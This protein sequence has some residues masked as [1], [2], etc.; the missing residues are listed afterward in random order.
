MKN[1][2]KKIPFILLIAFEL[3]VGIMLLLE[4]ALFTQIM[5][6]VFGVALIALGV[7]HL[8]DYFRDRKKGSSNAFALTFSIVLMLAGLLIACF[9][10][11]L[12]GLFR[13]PVMIYGVM[14][15]IFGIY[16]IGFY[17][18]MRS[19]GVPMTVIP[20][21]SAV[22]A[23]VAGIIIVLNPTDALDLMWRISGIIHILLAFSDTVALLLRPA[24]ESNNNNIIQQ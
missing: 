15:V 17:F 12:L 1:L 8:V 18:D 16:R 5:V 3:I 9:S 22:V 14:L 19:F 23:I 10:Q 6:I 13:L 20:I 24:P 21:V 11:A 4:P 7:I 2:M